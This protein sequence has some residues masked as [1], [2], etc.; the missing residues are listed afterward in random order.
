MSW[1]QRRKATY[2][3]GISGFFLIIF[4]IFLISYLSKPET[5][6]DSKQNQGEQG[7]DCGGP[8]INLCRAEYGDPSVLWVRWAKVTS[9]G[10]YNI[11]AYIENPNIEAGAYDVPYRLKIYDKDGVLI[12]EK[13]GLAYI[14]PNK[15][16]A[17]FEDNIGINDKVPARVNFE[18]SNN[19]VWQKIDSKELGITTV[20]KQISKEETKPRLDV[21]LK[22]KT[23]NTINNIEITAILYDL[24]DNAIAFSKTMIDS[25]VR[26]TPEMITFTWPE[27]FIKKVYRIETISKV[28][29]RT[30]GGVKLK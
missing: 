17:V 8:C 1:A 4:L 27:P 21:V 7:I 18:F 30:A 5:C 19:A 25:L 6:T 23:L 22:N 20:S 29:D 10:R 16:S 2:V 15:N 26:D 28:L 24:D 3:L 12:F 11:L 9:S 13:M 14:P